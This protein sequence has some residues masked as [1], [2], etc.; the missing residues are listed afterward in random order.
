M[1][2]KADKKGRGEMLS[3]YCALTGTSRD[4]AIKRFNRQLMLSSV[5]MKADTCKCKR[6]RPS[7][8]NR[9][10]EAIV[11]ECWQL[12][13]LICAEKLHPMLDVY[14][15]QL[16][17]NKM[18]SNYLSFDIETVRAISLG[19]L[20]NIIKGF[21]RPLTKRHKGN[22][23]IYQKVP[24]IADFGKYS[25]DKPGYPGYIEVDFVEHNGGSSNG[26]FAVTGI[27]TDLYSQWTVR[28]CGYGK[29]LQSVT[30]IDK[31][32][33][34]KIPF[35]CLHY[36]PDNDKA[37]LKILF[38]RVREN[39][40][41]KLSRSRP[42]KKNDNAHVEQKGGDKV[43]KLIGYFRFDTESEVRL[44]NEIY[45]RADLIDNYFIACAK[46]KEKVKDSKGKTIKKIYEPPMTPY[47]R[48]VICDEVP[49]E[50]KRRLKKIYG[51]LNMVKLKQEIDMLIEELINSKLGIYTQTKKKFHGQKLLSIQ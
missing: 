42:Y 32:A 45:K 15:E 17:N 36:H 24:I 2:Q 8:Y 26:A 46:L 51:R 9:V 23:F 41:I 25:Y 21:P 38:E 44:L 22:A 37:I 39:P 6:G 40:V 11:K 34:E 3:Q 1:Y 35:D 33:H 27:Y 47:Q 10:H 43:R 50:L 4:A 29:N 28:A 31:I 18:L 14:I 48:L 16:L 12:A 13:G 20:K 49:N 5:A 7:H 30:E 19:T